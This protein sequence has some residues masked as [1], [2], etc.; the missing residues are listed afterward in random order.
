MEKSYAPVLF[1][2]QNGHGHTIPYVKTHEINL[3]NAFHYIL[4]ENALADPILFVKPIENEESPAFSFIFE[5]KTMGVT[6][7][8][9]KI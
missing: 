8:V 2:N 7:L 6:Q 4:N 1:A 3:R 9:L 5:W